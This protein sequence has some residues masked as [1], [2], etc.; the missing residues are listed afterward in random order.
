MVGGPNPQYPNIQNSYDK[1]YDQKAQ[2][3]TQ[4]FVRPSSAN[5]KRGN[6]N[7]ETSNDFGVGLRHIVGNGKKGQSRGTQGNH[8]MQLGSAYGKKVMA[9]QGKKMHGQNFVGSN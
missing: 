2:T 6:N 3:R 1:K 4:N 8:T 7:V 5:S 9:S